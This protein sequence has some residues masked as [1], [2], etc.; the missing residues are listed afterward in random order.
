MT[1]PEA[2]T[3]M[4]FFISMFA[5]LHVFEEHSHAFYMHCC[6]TDI[7][8]DDSPATTTVVGFFSS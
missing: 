3:Q 8:T 6:Y 4:P 2:P 5:G 1:P 7:L